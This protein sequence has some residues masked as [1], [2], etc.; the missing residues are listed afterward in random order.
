MRISKGA[1]LVVIAVLVPF[2]VEFRTALSWFGIEL[3]ILESLVLGGMAVLAVVLWAV[4]P[5]NG[6]A[7]AELSGS[8]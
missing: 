3:S 6:N 7:E 4:W 1:L 8:S 5:P 2:V